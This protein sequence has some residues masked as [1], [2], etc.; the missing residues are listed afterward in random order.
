METLVSR[1]ICGHGCSVV[2][3]CIV[4]STFCISVWLVVPCP[5]LV[6]C[7]VVALPVPNPAVMLKIL[8]SLR[9]VARPSLVPLHVVNWHSNNIL[10]VRDPV[11]THLG[12]GTPRR[13]SEPFGPCGRPFDR[14]RTYQLW[15]WQP[16]AMSTGPNGSG[17]A[18]L[19]NTYKLFVIM[20]DVSSLFYA[21]RNYFL[22]NNVKNAMS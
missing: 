15:T 2:C 12:P 13:T 20:I 3:V 5:F 22:R 4:L 14:L 9:V 18:L 7:R 1:V 16:T 17:R 11:P 19:R 21:S 6:R 8:E 10:G